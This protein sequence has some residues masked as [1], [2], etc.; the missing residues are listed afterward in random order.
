MPGSGESGAAFGINPAKPQAW[1][2]EGNAKGNWNSDE[3]VHE[4]KLDALDNRFVWRTD[5]MAK[6]FFFSL[7]EARDIESKERKEDEGKNR[8]F[9][10]RGHQIAC[11]FLGV[12]G[13]LE[14]IEPRPTG[15]WSRLIN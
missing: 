10:S 14:E 11:L 12:R 8:D 1:H 2:D 9:E 7:G 5:A 6:D 15:E 3:G 4:S 13:V